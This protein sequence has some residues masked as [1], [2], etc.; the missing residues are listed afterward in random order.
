MSSKPRL[1]TVLL[2]DVNGFWCELSQLYWS[3]Q[4][5][6]LVSRHPLSSVEEVLSLYCPQCLARYSDDE[7]FASHGY[8]STCLQCPYC[9]SI[10]SN[11][12]ARA[13]CL[14]CAWSSTADVQNGILQDTRVC[15]KMIGGTRH[16]KPGNPPRAD[17]EESAWFCQ[18]PSRRRR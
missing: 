11:S 17:T 16:R 1:P 5:C 4:T 9:T 6:T 2:S 18:S 15:E 7:A 13:N 14:N 12:G 8:C 3:Q 10:V